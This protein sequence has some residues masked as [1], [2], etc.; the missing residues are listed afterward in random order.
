MLTC[1]FTWWDDPHTIHGNGLMQVVQLNTF[2]HYWTHADFDI[3][4]P[5]TYTLWA[6]VAAVAHVAPNSDG[7]TLNSQLFHALNLITHLAASLCVFALLRRLAKNDL[8]A[9]IGALFWAIHPLQVESVG[10]ISGYKDVLSGTLVI[11]CLERFVAWR[12]GFVAGREGFVAGREGFVAGRDRPSHQQFIAWMT[13]LLLALLAKPSAITTPL[14][15]LVIDRLILRT[16]WRPA[17]RAF[18]IAGLVALP[19]VIAAKLIQPASTTVSPLW[20]R[21]LI[22]GDSLAFYLLKIAL[23]INLCIDYGRSPVAIIGSGAIYYTWLLPAAIGTAIAAWHRRRARRSAVTD[24]LP[25][26]AAWIFVL[27]PLH[28]LGL[29]RFDFQHFSTVTDHYVYV[30]M[31][32]PALLLAALIR[33]APRWATALA[34][35]GVI[36]LGVL[37]FQLTAVWSDDAAL[38]NHAIAV[39]PASVI[40]NVNLAGDF[41]RAGRVREQLYLLQ[42]AERL[43]TQYPLLY[44]NYAGYY[45]VVGDFESADAAY[46]RALDLTLNSSAGESEK[47]SAFVGPIDRY[48]RLHRI[49]D[50]QRY[51]DRA[52]T[53]FP[54]NEALARRQTHLRA[55]R[56]DPNFVKV[57]SAVTLA[58]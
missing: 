50:A 28:V 45:I 39:N 35:A 15:L 19:F 47:I 11:A 24:S 23:P 41:A 5:L 6:L 21:P 9:M 38:M 20:A 52:L 57:P 7:I 31:L 14:L 4:I 55:I 48:V 13:C 22:A 29:T 12:E 53:L 3:Y 18:V 37:S 40:A 10:W 44:T 56:S 54:R 36:V 16:P 33:V 17:L 46:Q 34:G 42:Q 58:S 51:L 49:D 8:A 2:T 43:S 1:D 27:A 32:G 30:A 25:A 26:A